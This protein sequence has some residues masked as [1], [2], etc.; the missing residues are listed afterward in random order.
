RYTCSAHVR[1]GSRR[2]WAKSQSGAARGV[3]RG[4]A[5]QIRRGRSPI[6]PGR[7]P[8]RQLAKRMTIPQSRG[9]IALTG[10]PVILPD[11]IASGQAVIVAGSQIVGIIAAGEL[12]A[13][14]EI[15]DVAGRY[16]A[17]GLIDIH[18]HGAYGYTF[19]EPTTT[20]F[21]TI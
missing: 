10:G 2:S 4:T 20:A 21:A 7:A 3:R 15:I 8:G 6:C 12:G 11:R 1:P 13:S 14:I 19:N 9:C 17:P 16:I 18:T 5:W